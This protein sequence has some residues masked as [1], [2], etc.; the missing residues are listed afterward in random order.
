M[1]TSLLFGVGKRVLPTMI[2]CCLGVFAVA[3]P[4]SAQAPPPPPPPAIQA[5]CTVQSVTIPPAGPT[6]QIKGYGSVTNIPAGVT[7]VSIT[8]DF[9]KKANGAVAW[10]PIATVVQTANP[11]NGTAT[12]DT[13]FLSLTPAPARGD[14]Y[15]VLVSASYVSGGQMITIPA[16][17]SAAVTPVP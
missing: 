14:Q 1:E 3:S 17:G 16:V 5:N 10:A 7:N 11:V 9:Q 12:Y 6:W 4:A 13:G 2:L 8:I 15:R